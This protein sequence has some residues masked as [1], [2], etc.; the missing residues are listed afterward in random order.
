MRKQI[1][2]VAMLALAACATQSAVVTPITSLT[3]SSD[4]TVD[5]LLALNA[6]CSAEASGVGAPKPDLK[7]AGGMGVEAVR[8]ETLERFA[9]VFSAAASRRGPFLIEF[10]I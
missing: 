3:S 7:L 2:S 1:A 5:A 4:A 10:R 8:V 9:D 6:L